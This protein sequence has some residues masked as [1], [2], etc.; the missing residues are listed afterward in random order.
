MKMTINTR[1]IQHLGK[2][3][4]TS[5]DV[6]I[7]ELIKNSID[8]KARNISLRLYDMFPVTEIIPKEVLF[9]ID[10]KL[11]EKPVLV[12]EDDG[13]GMADEVIQNGF[14]DVGTRIKEKDETLLGEKGIG[15]LA[16]Q[17]LG[18]AVLLETC[19]VEENHTSYVF[20]NWEDVIKGKNDVPYIA[21]EKA[22]IHTRLWI[23]DVRIEDYIENAVQFQQQTLFEDQYVAYPNRNMKTAISFLISPFDHKNTREI[24]IKFFYR[25][26]EIDCGFQY[27]MISLAESCHTFNIVNDHGQISMECGL[28]LRPWFVERI[29]RSIVKATTFSRLRRPHSY[30]RD[31][32]ER[33]KSRVANVLT[34]KYSQKELAY[35]LKTMLESVIPPF[36]GK[37]NEQEQYNDYLIKQ[38]DQILKDLTEIIPINGAV[39][40]FKQDYAIGQNI[41]IA[42]AA[43][44][45]HACKDLTYKDIKRFLDDNN[46][47][48]LYRGKYR[49]GF[50]GNK[51]NDWIKLQQFRTKGQQWYR[52]DLGN[53]VGY[54][55]LTDIDQT[56]IQEISSRL[57]ISQNEYSDALKA[58]INLV[59]NYFFYELN[60][61]A[62][63]IVR[64]LLEEDGQ[65]GDSIPKRLKKNQDM[66][67]R[68][69]AT[70]KILLKHID[71]LSTF[72]NQ[73]ISVGEEQATL[74]LRAYEK[75]T[76]SITKINSAATAQ[77]EIQN[78]AKI[79][80]NEASDRLHSI[81]IEAYNNYKL[82]AN[83]MITETITHELDSIR[84]TSISSD[85][86][87]HFDALRNY[88]EE[89]NGIRVYNQHVYPIRS[90][91]EVLASRLQQVGSMYSFLETTFIHKGA[92]DALVLQD[93]EVLV[94]AI[95]DN[96]MM[97]SSIKN[98]LLTSNLNGLTWLVPKGVMLH[99]FY[100]LFNNSLYWIDIRRKWAQEDRKYYKEGKDEIRVDALSEK[101]I[102][103][104]DTGT[105]VIRSMEDILFEP[106]ESGKEKDERRGMGLYIVQKLMR[107]FGGDIELLADRNTYGHRY[108]FLLTV[109]TQEE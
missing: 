90:N 55:S 88:L 19:S 92:Y 18:S 3:L 108:R 46:G 109:R 81:E 56:K 79:V 34:M 30:Y 47:V 42:A 104:S 98:V 73:E 75:V 29:H 38:A 85:D 52:F 86:E 93:L 10:K 59:F 83:G 97:S 64:I 5:P 80:V 39:Y 1:V 101:E 96:L 100:N 65:L 25:N 15:R 102:V 44:M 95:K 94:N 84:K 74:S 72:L 45:G 21:T 87:R 53:T 103:I 28:S 27:D 22:S 41:V 6:A 76:N 49:I 62:N 23:L 67:R 40:S 32:L 9:W 12:V 66:L 63:N 35:F 36:G 43:E 105:G 2:D 106:L 54:V 4:I 48:K 107:S 60:R 13:K 16:T 69:Q 91:Y 37:D 14:L 61:K 50:L 20:I 78:E 82:M 17:R 33:N 31:L 11:F 24:K 68:M 8:A 57:D 51:E 71:E 77:Q 70:N 26:R 7:V 89:V 58:C 99:V